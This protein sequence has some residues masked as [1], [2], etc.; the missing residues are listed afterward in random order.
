[1]LNDSTG[2]TTPSLT[3]TATYTVRAQGF[4]QIATGGLLTI[5]DD[6]NQPPDFDLPAAPGGGTWTS[7]NTEDPTGFIEAGLFDPTGP[8]GDTAWII[9]FCD[10]PVTLLTN[11][12]LV[13][14]ENTEKAGLVQSDAGNELFTE[15]PASIGGGEY[16]IDIAY[17]SH[18]GNI[19][20]L[21]VRQHPTGTTTAFRLI[22][23]EVT[24]AGGDIVMADAYYYFDPNNI[25]VGY[26]YTGFGLTFDGLPPNTIPPYNTNHL[27]DSTI[28]GDGSAQVVKFSD[29]DYS[30]NAASAISVQ[31]C[32]AGL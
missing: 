31:I 2:I 16:A 19:L 5:Y 18:T 7:I 10:I 25:N 6:G 15:V 9:M 13:F 21:N 1:M 8:D 28:T 22:R 12:R 14:D 3:N 20:A 30:D 11:V 26:P 17:A 4:G 27:Y 23:M 24:T 32:G 29:T